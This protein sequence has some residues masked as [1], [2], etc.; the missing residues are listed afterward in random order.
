MKK[1]IILS[2]LII[3]STS[4]FGCERNPEKVKLKTE[5]EI[6][7]ESV[8]S[9]GENTLISTTN[10]K[11]SVMYTFIDSE[12]GFEYKM[13]SYARAMNIDSA[14]YGYRESTSSDFEEKYCKF[15]FEKIMEEEPFIQP[16]EYKTSSIY[17]EKNEY[18]YYR[19]ADYVYPNE[20]DHWAVFIDLET[21][22]PASIYAKLYSNSTS[23]L[24]GFSEMLSEKIRDIDKRKYFIDYCI[25]TY[26]FAKEDGSKVINTGRSD[27]RTNTW[28]DIEAE[29]VEDIRKIA[30]EEYDV[31][32]GDFI[33]K[34]K[35]PKE[36]LKE[37]IENAGYEIY[38][39]VTDRND[40]DVY[41]FE[42][43]EKEIFVSEVRIKD[44]RGKITH[45]ASFSQ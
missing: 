1:C 30:R 45:W 36:D 7:E 13:T 5:K 40:L 20:T 22:A 10:G 37:A 3:L 25:R 14:I 26:I 8:F 16:F 32:L 33:R 35:V 21:V 44:K 17:N 34:E 19:N 11:N 42:Y 18:T 9:Y 29:S 31:K 15:I 23:N 38:Y 41:Y 2:I 43:N 6:M 27:I 24:I 28:L 4:L 12:Y 39:V